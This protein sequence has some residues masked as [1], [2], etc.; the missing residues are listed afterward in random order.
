MPR[1]LCKFLSPHRV[2]LIEMAKGTRAGGG[3]SSLRAGQRRR[4]QLLLLGIGA[5]SR[6][7][8]SERRLDLGDQILVD[9]APYE[10]IGLIWHERSADEALLCRRIV[11]KAAPPRDEPTTRE[12]TWW[13]TRWHA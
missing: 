11:A 9:N 1:V 2:Y 5:E 12:R 8:V 7:L 3:G 6:E 10:V 13:S 4:Y